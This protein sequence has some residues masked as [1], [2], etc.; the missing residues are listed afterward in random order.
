[1]KLP[2]FMIAAPSSGSGKTMITCGILTALKN[3]GLRTA[4]FK[5]GPDYIDP[6]FHQRV[7]GIPSWN[8]D[9][10]FT[11]RNEARKLLAKHSCHSDVAVLEGVMGYY[12]GIGGVTSSAGSYDLADSTGTPVI[13]VVN[14]KGMSLSLAALIRGFLDFKK[15]SHV[16]G[17]ILNRI[18]PSLYPE[19]KKVLEETLSIRV[20]GYV[21]EIPECA[22]ESRHLGLFLPDEI[23]GLAERMERLSEVL[24]KSVDLDAVLRIAGEAPELNTGRSPD[25]P[26]SDRKYRKP[27]RIAVAEDEAFCFLYADNLEFLRNA[28]AEIIPFSPLCDS[29]LP[30]RIDGLILCGGYPE[31]HARRLSE[32]RI[33]RD[34]IRGRI[35]DG[36]PCIAECGGFLYLHDSLKDKEGTVHQMCG[37]IPGMAFW[38][39]KLTRFGY[40]NLE[41]NPGKD[42]PFGCSEC[43]TIRA[44]EFHYFESDFPGDSFHAAKPSG[45]REW[46]CMHAS[47]SLLAGFPH[48][49]YPGCPELILAF[50]KKAAGWQPEKTDIAGGE[51]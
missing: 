49:Y 35:R 47:K 12:D 37:V 34:E 1:M 17:V 20:L 50:L 31:N 28:G 14:A 8:L 22:F 10:F 29:H 40:V 11:G 7:I 2:R 48:L 15:E 39:G 23:N 32:N 38:N 13:L 6:M 25:L 42:A 19:I 30:E 5:C 4:A 21:P 26:S 43:E 45:K 3:R 24:K 51:A 33:L 36:L 41:L 18:A 44:H 46:D 27:V 9:L 16:K